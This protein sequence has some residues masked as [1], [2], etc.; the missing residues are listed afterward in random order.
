HI[1]VL[2][3]PPCHTGQIHYQGVDLRFDGGPAMTDLKKLELTTG[4]S[5]AYTLYVPLRFKRFADR[6]PGP[7]ARDADRDA[8]KQKLGAIGKFLLDWQNTYDKTIA[9]KTT[10][11][12]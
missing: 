4:L 8:L 2:P 7:E 5:I 9:S 10:W 1:A 3:G 6:V 12:G 11:D